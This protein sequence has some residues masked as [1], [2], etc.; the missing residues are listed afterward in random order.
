MVRGIC[1]R[2]QLITQVQPFTLNSSNSNTNNNN[3]SNWP[4][5]NDLHRSVRRPIRLQR[6]TAVA[7]VDQPLIRFRPR[8]NHLQ[9]HS[10]AVSAAAYTYNKTRHNNYPPS[11]FSIYTAHNNTARS[12]L[13]LLLLSHFVNLFLSSFFFYYFIF[14]LDSFFLS[15]LSAPASSVLRKCHHR[16]S[17]E[18]KVIIFV[19]VV[20]KAEGRELF[21]SRCDKTKK[22]ACDFFFKDFVKGGL[23][24]NKRDKTSSKCSGYAHLFDVCRIIFFASLIA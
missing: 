18:Q 7:A 11:S 13:P 12:P 24:V 10:L 9:T 5:I 21:I 19:Y 15:S 16:L 20:R 17:L 6:S 3:S 4:T 2:M 22:R 1:R 23:V 8:T 14:Q